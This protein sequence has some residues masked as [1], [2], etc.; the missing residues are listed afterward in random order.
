MHSK[1]I[2]I[3][4]DAVGV[5]VPAGLAV[6]AVGGEIGPLAAL[7]RNLAHWRG[8]AATR[9]FLADDLRESGDYAAADHAL[10]VAEFYDRV[11]MRCQNFD[12]ST[13][14]NLPVAGTA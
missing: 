3:A 5:P 10:F 1:I 9:R 7:Y 2:V 12:L 6:G 8:R 14:P 4:A 13:P 11:S